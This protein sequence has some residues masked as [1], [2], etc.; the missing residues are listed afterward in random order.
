MKH[1][2][3]PPPPGPSGRPPRPARRE[4]P[5]EG[6]HVCHGPALED[7]PVYPQTIPPCC[8]HNFTLVLPSGQE[9]LVEADKSLPLMDILVRLCRRYQL[10]TAAHT[11]ELF[12]KGACQPLPFKPNATLAE[13]QPGLVVLRRRPPPAERDRRRPKEMPEPTVR[14]LVNFYRTQKTFVRVSPRAPLRIVAP[15]I[16]AKC[17][18]E[19]RATVLF[20][21]ASQTERLDGARSL[22]DFGLREVYAVDTSCATLRLPASGS[23]KINY[24]E[25]AS[26]LD[27]PRSL[28]KARE[29]STKENASI[30]DCL[31]SK[32][33]KGEVKVSTSAPTSPSLV[34]PS[35]PYNMS[36]SVSS[37][38]VAAPCLTY[39][40]VGRKR[41]APAPPR[42]GPSHS[43]SE[44][45]NRPHGES[46][47]RPQAAVAA[48]SRAD[49]S[50]KTAT[51]ADDDD[52]GVTQAAGHAL[53]LIDKSQS[54]MA[55]RERTR[56]KVD[57]MERKDDS[58]DCTIEAT[59]K[60]GVNKK[61][62]KAD[63]PEWV[64]ALR[65]EKR[66]VLRPAKPSVYVV[67]MT[68]P[69]PLV[70]AK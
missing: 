52:K 9:R 44:G 23:A 16:G 7:L 5:T 67:Y 10:N 2:A 45:L 43:Y 56:S 13:L 1:R 55:P 3:P 40:T 6:Q 59:L 58:I 41:P 65:V 39:G 11:L 27:T 24:A 38:S 33:K 20:R 21:N 30:F 70:P 8:Q 69:S 31:R 47:V 61:D 50:T 64:S 26:T 53:L 34:A 12:S 57:A 28:A 63:S 19:Q 35:R 54:V 36:A 60:E 15:I 48:I 37:S 17:G 68:K 22:D 18:F 49:T 4:R 29:E 46:A 51:K 25:K 42:L 66:D 62:L 32:G 14:V